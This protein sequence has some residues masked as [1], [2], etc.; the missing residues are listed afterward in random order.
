MKFK[1]VFIDDENDPRLERE[2]DEKNLKK[3]P[4][5]ETGNW[6]DSPNEIKKMVKDFSK[7]KKQGEKKE[8]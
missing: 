7:K 2:I 6:W 5:I 3:V 1:D 4:N 8:K